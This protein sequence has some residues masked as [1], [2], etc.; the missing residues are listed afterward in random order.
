[1]QLKTT[2]RLAC[3]FALPKTA[4]SLQRYQLYSGGRLPGSPCFH[5]KIDHH[6]V[7]EDSNEIQKS[8]DIS[9]NP[10]RLQMMKERRLRTTGLLVGISF[11]SIASALGC[12]LGFFDPLLFLG[13][14]VIGISV[15]YGI[16]ESYNEYQA[17][18]PLSSFEVQQSTVPDAGMGLF[19][20]INIVESTYLFDYEGEVIT[21]EEYFS[22][23][24]N[25]DGRYVAR[26]DTGCFS[27]LGSEPVY[28]DGID[29][30][31]SNVARYMNSA[32]EN[33][34]NVYW[35]KQQFGSQ[36]G[37]MHFYSLKDIQNG[38]ELL[39]DYG[40]TYWQVADQIDSSQE[41]M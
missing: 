41:G 25:G 34:A 13:L 35:K 18:L 38:D 9:P 24:P 1:M 10:L 37:A 22:R 27:L 40:S 32:T 16:T 4:L 7:N 2:H 19:A 31:K 23:Y 12:V 36:A 28:I 8:D 30:E 15:G 11:L 5:P 33:K 14:G 29:P 6:Q 26:V 20:G 3:P 17:P 21:E 39:F